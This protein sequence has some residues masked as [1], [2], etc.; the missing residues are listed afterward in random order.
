MKA[1]NIQWDT[2]GD[3]ELFEELPTEIQ[4]PDELAKNV[5]EDGYN[6][7]ISDYISDVTGFCHY[8][9]ELAE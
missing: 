9:F 2:D 3:E 1:T 5:D 8:G 6:D 4:I 7:E